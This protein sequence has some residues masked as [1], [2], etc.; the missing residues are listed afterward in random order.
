ML[1]AT[2]SVVRSSAFSARPTLQ[3]NAA[4]MYMRISN[5]AANRA[6]APSNEPQTNPDILYTGVSFPLLAQLVRSELFSSAV[7]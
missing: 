3:S 6:A 1:R 4:H 5:S 7:G 2:A